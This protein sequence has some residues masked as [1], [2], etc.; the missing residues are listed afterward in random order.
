[1]PPP[2]VAPTQAAVA[3]LRPLQFSG[4]WKFD[5]VLIL[6]GGNWPVRGLTSGRWPA[7]DW[8][9]SGVEE[10][11]DGARLLS[12]SRSK[13]RQYSPVLYT[14]HVRQVAR[15]LSLEEVAEVGG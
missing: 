11:S 7:D 10:D 15:V 9:G 4:V 13:R 2:Q 1:M 8:E 5:A 12:K 3:V 14:G 6:L